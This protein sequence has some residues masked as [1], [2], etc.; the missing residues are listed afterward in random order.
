MSAGMFGDVGQ[1]FDDTGYTCVGNS[2]ARNYCPTCSGDFGHQ[3]Q[4]QILAVPLPHAPGSAR[5]PRTVH[6]RTAGPAHVHCAAGVEPLHTGTRREDLK[7]VWSTSAARRR[8]VRAGMTRDGESRRA[9][10]LTCM[11][12]RVNRQ[13]PVPRVPGRPSGQNTRCW[14][15]V[16]GPPRPLPGLV[17]RVTPRAL[18]SVRCR[19][20]PVM[21][22]SNQIWQRLLRPDERASRGS[23]HW[24]KP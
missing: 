3:R 16:T 19:V 15:R 11:A 12:A 4:L 6:A 1:S 8:L 21:G 14:S 23:M 7:W 2:A 20:P 13:I 9:A 10:P 17:R 5:H 22:R 24:G 18:P